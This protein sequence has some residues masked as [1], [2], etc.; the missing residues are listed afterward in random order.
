MTGTTEAPEKPYFLPPV[1]QVHLTDYPGVDAIL[2]CDAHGTPTPDLTWTLPPDVQGEVGNGTALLLRGITSNHSGIYV[3]T[4][5][6]SAGEANLTITIDVREHEPVV[7]TVLI[8]KEDVNQ[9]LGFALVQCDVDGDPKPNVTWSRVGAAMSPNV[10]VQG[11]DI[12]MFPPDDEVGLY[13]CNASNSV[14]SDVAYYALY[15]TTG[16]LACDTT[17][18]SPAAAETGRV[19]RGPCPNACS[20]SV[21][22]DSTIKTFNSTDKIC[23]SAIAA[24]EITDAGGDVMWVQRENNEVT[25]ISEEGG[26]LVYNP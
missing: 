24:G 22:V 25:F 21:T 5:K 26:Q 13:V 23:E 3:C 17:F 19:L 10:R 2:R 8:P 9:K 18:D 7:A 12:V 20:G 6:N 4:A 16:Q 1:R 11:K 14:E 15:R